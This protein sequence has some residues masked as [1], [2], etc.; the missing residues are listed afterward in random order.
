M[1]FDSLQEETFSKQIPNVKPACWYDFD[2]QMKNNAASRLDIVSFEKCKCLR[3]DLSVLWGERCFAT[4]EIEKRYAN[5]LKLYGCLSLQESVAPELANLYRLYRFLRGWGDQIGHV[6]YCTWE[7]EGLTYNFYNYET[8]YVQEFKDKEFLQLLSEDNLTEAIARAIAN[9]LET[10][11]INLNENTTPKKF[12]KM[13]LVM[14]T[15]LANEYGKKLNYWNGKAIGCY[16]NMNNNKINSELVFSLSNSCTG[17][18]NRNEVKLVD[19]GYYSNA[20]LLDTPM[21]IGIAEFV[22]D[23]SYSDFKDKRV[24]ESILNATEGKLRTLFEEFLIKY[25][26]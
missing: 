6:P 4:E 12:L 11:D 18:L 19:S 1:T 5:I 9:K 14:K 3:Y 26:V 13:W 8:A 15:L 10:D 7:A 25:K 17:Y 2:E 24:L 22:N 23:V 20:L 21:Y 16:I